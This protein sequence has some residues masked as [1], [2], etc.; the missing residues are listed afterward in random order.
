MGIEL[1]PSW[2]ENIDFFFFFFINHE[3]LPLCGPWAMH[4][5][6]SNKLLWH[7]SCYFFFP[8]LLCNYKA[9]ITSHGYR[10]QRCSEKLKHLWRPLFSI[11]RQEQMIKYAFYLFRHHQFHFPI[12]TW[13]SYVY[14][15][16]CSRCA[17]KVIICNLFF[18]LLLECRLNEIGRLKGRTVCFQDD[19]DSPW[20]GV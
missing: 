18:F 5:E 8:F 12:S 13:T 1:R 3:V 16:K 11:N 4:S 20:S 19:D 2:G 7:F 9:V 15:K 10:G 6:T 14:I 17:S